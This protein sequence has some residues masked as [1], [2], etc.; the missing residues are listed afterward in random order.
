M[1]ESHEPTQNKRI[2]GG[3]ILSASFATMCHSPEDIVRTE[4]PSLSSCSTA[5]HTLD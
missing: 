1:F 2:R 5:A 4:T 3:P